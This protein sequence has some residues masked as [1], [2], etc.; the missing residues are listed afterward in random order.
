MKG[1]E[2]LR[3][4]AIGVLLALIPLLGIGGLVEETALP[5]YV[6]VERQNQKTGQKEVVSEHVTDATL[7]FFDT[8]SGTFTFF[9]SIAIACFTLTL[10]WSTDKLWGEAKEQRRD[11]RRAIFASVMNANAARKAN[12]IAQETQRIQTRPYVHY[13]DIGHRDE[14]RDRDGKKVRF[15]SFTVM[16]Q[17]FGESPARYVTLRARAFVGGYWSEDFPAD[18]DDFRVIPLGVIPPGRGVGQDGFYA[19]YPLD[20]HQAYLDATA[21]IFVEGR[22]EYTDAFNK[23]YF[24]NFRQVCSGLESVKTLKFRPTPGWNDV[25]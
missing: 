23:P 25:S 8:H 19:E 12:R 24:T 13:I 3:K 22:V 7:E 5:I 21:S 6:H 1:A 2:S 9:A 4:W 20:E 16:F 15:M 17:N 18:L 10:T 14:L 11:S